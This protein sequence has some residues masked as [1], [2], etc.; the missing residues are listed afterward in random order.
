[1]KY[2]LCQEFGKCFIY[3]ISFS[4]HNTCPHFP[5]KEVDITRKS[6]WLALLGGGQ[7]GNPTGCNGEGHLTN[8]IQVGLS[9]VCSIPR[10]SRVSESFENEVMIFVITP[11][12]HTLFILIDRNVSLICLEH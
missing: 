10:D 1:M 6:D 9:V 5:N 2:I 4:P 7:I 12:T 8:Y 3:I 11:T